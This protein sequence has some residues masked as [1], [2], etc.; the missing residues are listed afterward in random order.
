MSTSDKVYEEVL[1]YKEFLDDIFYGEGL[2]MKG[3][4]YFFKEVRNKEGEKKIGYNVLKSYYNNQA[5]VQIFKP[6]E[7]M[8][9]LD[10]VPIINLF[11]FERIY[12]DTMYLTLKNSVLAFINIIDGF[13]K[14]AFS[15]MFILKDK[16]SAIASSKAV[17]TFNDFLDEIKQ[18]NQ[19]LGYV[20]SDRGSE[21]LGE[22]M[23]H[24]ENKK[25]IHIYANV[26]DKRKTSII[27]RFN[28]TMRLMIEK[29]RLVYGKIDSNIVNKLISSY[30]NIPHSNLKYSPLQILESKEIQNKVSS[31]NYNIKKSIDPIVPIDGYVRVLIRKT[32]KKVSPVWTTQLYKIKNVS[33]G[34]YQLEG[35]DGYFKRDELQSVNKDQLM[36]HKIRIDVERETENIEKVINNEPIYRGRRFEK[37]EYEPLKKKTDNNINLIKKQLEDK[38]VKFERELCTILLIEWNKK[39]KNYV[40]SLMNKKGDEFEVY[41]YE[42]LEQNRRQDW[43][44]EYRKIYDDFIKKYIVNKK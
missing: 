26:G 20:I 21:F 25:I 32:F 3:F 24:L 4:S 33:N 5:V 30:N 13:S 10:Y 22:F 16:A 41:L 40:A 9:S 29:Y 42:L 11:P 7:T 6:P 18:Y 19:E 27:E 28:K 23:K 35:L 37:I 8:K 17:S 12:I 38:N 44:E 15:R 34:N 14:Y 39:Y 31:D 43:Y 36:S 1:K 2:L